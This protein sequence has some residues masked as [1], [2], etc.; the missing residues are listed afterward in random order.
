LSIKSFS[1]FLLFSL[2]LLSMLPRAGASP[3]ITVS[4]DK[5]TYYR[6]EYVS[7]F[8][9][10]APP[11]CVLA[12]QIS[13]PGGVVYLEETR[14]DSQGRASLQPPYTFRVPPDA[15]YGTYTIYVSG[16]G[17]TGSGT[18]SVTEV[19]PPPPPPP[20]G[21]PKES[22]SMTV[23]VDKEVIM[24]GESVSIR[25]ILSP[26]LDVTVR[27]RF[28]CPNG[29]EVSVSVSMLY[30]VFTYVF[31]PDAP[32]YWRIWVTW[33]GNAQ[34]EGC[35]SNTVGVVVRTPVSLRVIAA[36]SIVGVGGAIV[37]YADTN[38]P[39]K[40]KP[41]LISYFS[42]RTRV[43]RTIGVFE[44]SSE[45]F[46]ACVFTPSET[47]EYVFK[48]EWVGDPAYMPASANSS[49]V[50][51]TAEPVTA[52]DIISMLSRLRELQRLLEEKE[53]ELEASRSTITGLQKSIAELQAGLS[54]AQSRISSLEKQLAETES[55][56][57]EAESRARFTTIL[58][59]LSG[60][61][62]GLI[63]GYLL[64]KRRSKS[65]FPLPPE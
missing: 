30:G 35:V 51:V 5:S 46:I 43:W 41:L 6:E 54:S 18:F 59:L 44:T 40:H 31:K 55:K 25:S 23:S 52:E 64:F 16:C 36:P 2:L 61:L 58:G 38:P 47:G 62:I 33:E 28:A 10:N 60:L 19:P 15:I 11:N 13:N 1:T 48:A 20:P 24:L 37:V 8:I 27:L 22:T 42:N 7:I 14:T 65:S 32:G 9:S 17:D 29:S 49:R 57:S 3:S 56:V 53:K 21:P 4:T 26:G 34:Y 12:V 50:L 39:L 63:L 45:G